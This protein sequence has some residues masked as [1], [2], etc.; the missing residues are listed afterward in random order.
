VRALGH[1]GSADAA[2]IGRSY[3]KISKSQGGVTSNGPR[4]VQDLCNAIGR[5]V[6]LTRQL[7][8]THGEGLEFFSQMFARMDRRKC[9][10][11]RP[12]D[13]Q[14]SPRSRVPALPR[15]SRNKSALCD[16]NPLGLTPKLVDFEHQ[17]FLPILLG[18]LVS[19]QTLGAQSE[20]AGIV[21]PIRTQRN[22][23]NGANRPGWIS[24]TA[25]RVGRIVC[26]PRCD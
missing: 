17:R 9:H 14:Q 23:L 4:S 2:K 7:S 12:S 24:D 10:S 26:Q 19:R 1:R 25:R 18:D 22:S 11:H 20:R 21:L 6:D 16:N 15:P 8:H 3:R 5:H 13:S